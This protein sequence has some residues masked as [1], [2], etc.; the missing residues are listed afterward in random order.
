L[1]FVEFHLFFR[2]LIAFLQPYA[3]V[4]PGEYALNIKVFSISTEKFVKT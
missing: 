1:F 3:L 4:K 2:F